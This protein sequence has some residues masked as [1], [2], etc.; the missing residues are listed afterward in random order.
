MPRLKTLA[1]VVL[2][3]LYRGDVTAREVDNVDVIA[4]ARAVVGVV[5]IAEDAQM[6]AAA[7]GDLRNERHEVVGDALRVLADEPA[8]CAPMGLK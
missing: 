1:A 2:H 4:H 5:V 6:V 3:I 7:D 8:S